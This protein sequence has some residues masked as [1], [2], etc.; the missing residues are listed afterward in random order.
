MRW[1]DLPR[2]L[3]FGAVA[4]ASW[5]VLA[6]FFNGT[7]S[8]ALLLKLHAAACVSLYLGGL[9][10]GKGGG[11]RVAALT[12]PIGLGIALLVGSPSTALLALGAVLAVG[13]S[14]LLWESRPLRALLLELL[15]VLG[16]LKAAALVGNSSIVGVALGYWTF[17]L[18]QGVF[19]LVGGVE[20]RPE[21]GPVRDPFDLARERA[22]RLLEDGA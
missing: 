2:S 11:A 8:L 7:A 19:F 13:R 14:V 4:A 15:L 6:V 18:V 22:L 20:A 3:V 16:G 17:F 21:A 12:L 10:P 1:N 5:L 9:A